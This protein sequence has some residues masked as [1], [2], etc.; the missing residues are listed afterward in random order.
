[1][2]LTAKQD[3]ARLLFLVPYRTSIFAWITTAFQHTVFVEQD[4]L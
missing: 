4:R 3:Q 1:M 2:A